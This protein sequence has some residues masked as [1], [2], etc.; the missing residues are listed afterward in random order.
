MKEKHGPSADSGDVANV[1]DDFS[2]S[3]FGCLKSSRRRFHFMNLVEVNVMPF[4]F[5]PFP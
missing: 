5:Y 2:K 4:G 3:F 1:S